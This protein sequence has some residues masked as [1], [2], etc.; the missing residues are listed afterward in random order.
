M[1]FYVKEQKVG[2]TMLKK[3]NALRE[4]EH[5]E[6]PLKRSLKSKKNVV[7]ED[8][9]EAFPV[10]VQMNWLQAQ[11]ILLQSSRDLRA[12]LLR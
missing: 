1:L 7:K 9:I 5:H 4:K 3:N 6:L 12:L 8:G 10:F 2:T 11:F